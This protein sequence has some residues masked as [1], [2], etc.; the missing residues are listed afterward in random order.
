ME[1][2]QQRWL[3]E[4]Q[5]RLAG[6]AMGSGDRPLLPASLLLSKREKG[7]VSADPNDSSRILLANPSERPIRLPLFLR[8]L[9]LR[10]LAS[11]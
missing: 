11:F 2:W 6:N 7:G 4:V 1:A 5:R 10:L 8:R 9:Q 3:G